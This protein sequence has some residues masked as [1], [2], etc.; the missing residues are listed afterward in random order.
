MKTHVQDV[1]SNMQLGACLISWGFERT[2]SDLS[3]NWVVNSGTAESMP[4]VEA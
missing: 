1:E 4:G 3:R 2:Y